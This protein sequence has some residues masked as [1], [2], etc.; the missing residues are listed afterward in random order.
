MKTKISV[1]FVDT[2]SVKHCQATRETIL[3]VLQD[4]REHDS[5]DALIS[6]FYLLKY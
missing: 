2:N 4:Q 6:D 1:M 3:P 5:A